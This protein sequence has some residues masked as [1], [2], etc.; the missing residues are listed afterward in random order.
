LIGWTRLAN[1]LTSIASPFT[2]VSISSTALALTSNHLSN[3]SKNLNSTEKAKVYQTHATALLI[4]KQHLS[5]EMHAN[6]KSQN[7]SDK[8][9]LCEKLRLEAL[10]VVQVAIRIAPWDIVGWSLLKIACK[11]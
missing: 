7:K 3:A 2:S 1:H 5:D 11:E 9:K 4:T 10:Q 8:V 6:E